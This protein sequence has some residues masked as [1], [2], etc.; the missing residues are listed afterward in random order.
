MGLKRLLPAAL[1]ALLAFT[2]LFPLSGAQPARAQGG[3]PPAAVRVAFQKMTP[4]E[5]IG[6]L[7]LV[8]FNG[9][10]IGDQSQVY[11]LIVN[12]HIGGVVLSAGNDNF[13]AAPNTLTAAY[14]LTRDLQEVEWNTALNPPLDPRTDQPVPHQYVPLLIGISQ[15]GDGPPGDQI[16]SGLTPLPSEMSIGATWS[17]DLASQAGAVMGSELSALGVNLY[18]GPSLDVVQTPNPTPLN[19]TGVSVF[20]GDP[21]WVSMMG[22]A[23]ITGLHTGSG[24]RLLVVA[25]HF[26]GRGSADRADELEIATVRK[27]LDELKQV[28][29]APFFAVTGGA[30]TPASTT[31]GLLLSHIRYQGFQGNIRATTKPV[32]FDAQALST[33]LGLKEFDTWHQQGGLIISDNLG[34]RAVKQ[35]YSTG[36]DFPARTVA[37]DAFVAGSD[38]LY[39]GNIVSSDAPDTYSTVLQI[40]T[41]FAQKYRDDPTFAQRV[42]ASV[43]RLLTVKY[44]LYGGFNVDTVVPDISRLDNLGESQQATFNVA[45]RAA[46]LLSPDARDLATVLP[47]PPQVRDRLIFL[48]D[49]TPAQQCSTCAQ[50]FVPDVQAMQNAITQLYG[51]QS[52][53]QTSSTFRMSSYSFKDIADYMA[54]KSPPYMP[55]DLDAADWVVISMLGSGDGQAQLISDFL[56]EQQDL[57]RDKHVILFAFGAPY[58]LD[59]TDISRLTAFYALYGKQPPF[60]EIAARVLFQE[61]TPSGASPVSIPGLGYDIITITSPDPNQI[62]PLSLDM[63]ATAAPTNGPTPEATPVPLFKIGDTIAIQAGPIKD[64][65]GKQ[66]PDGTVVHFVMT[67][68]GEGGGIA[69]QADATTTLGTARVSFG[70]DKPGLLQIRATSDPAMI[71]EVIQ[72]DVSSGGQPAAVTVIVPQLTPQVTPVVTKTPEPVEDEFITSGGRPKFSAWLVTLIIILAGAT[73]A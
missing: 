72:L 68:T 31:D 10:D 8:A 27:S 19:D 57:L 15:D 28:D 64:H 11:D 34:T 63:S 9:S 16:L 24:D 69:Q 56:S 37:R 14:G 33:I 65:N 48:S 2:I 36:T 25:K 62:I 66:V 71:S 58:Y 1:L 61:L 44:R 41:F 6:Q 5:R 3:G 23:Y 12:H 40:L 4:E 30:A 50:Q 67:V 45:G 49:I 32:S 60:V 35:F 43:L 59:A 55:G 38:L 17:P 42:D 39:L 51:P 54:G 22:S 20:G 47:N 21:Y 18:F 70:L 7:F 73:G 46:T 26:P 53:N 29:L 13:V 52:G